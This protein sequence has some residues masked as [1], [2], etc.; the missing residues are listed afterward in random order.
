MGGGKFWKSRKDGAVKA[1]Q[2]NVLLARSRTG[3]SEEERKSEVCNEKEN[4]KHIL[5]KCVKFG[6]IRERYEIEDEMEKEPKRILFSERKK[7]I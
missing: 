1:I 5:K 2:G 3:R 4:L 7:Y 6:N